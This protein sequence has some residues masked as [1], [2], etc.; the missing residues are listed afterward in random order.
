[1]HLHCWNTHNYYTIARLP[2]KTI[3]VQLLLSFNTLTNL[4]SFFFV[5]FIVQDSPIKIIKLP[6]QAPN[7]RYVAVDQEKPIVSNAEDIAQQ[8]SSFGILPHYLDRASAPPLLNAVNFSV[9]W[10]TRES[11][12]QI[13]NCPRSCPPSLT[14][15]AEPVCGSDGWL[16]AN[17][18][19]MRKKTC[20]RNG[21]I[22]VCY[23]YITT[24]SL[25]DSYFKTVLS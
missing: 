14:V 23:Q 4:A 20:S 6:E 13:E 5:L 21:S 19:D 18:C 3:H 11:R 25:T 8:L 16:Y 12:S 9:L 22:K 24:I 7:L 1:M 17:L 2:L 10:P 15:G